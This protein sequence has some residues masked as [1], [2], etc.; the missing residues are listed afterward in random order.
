MPLTTTEIEALENALSLTKSGGVY[1]EGAR[2]QGGTANRWLLVGVGGVG[3]LTLLRVKHEIMSR[4]KLPT[5]GTGKPTGKPPEN[6][7]FLA[8]DTKDG[9][10]EKMSC[11]DT[12]FDGEEIVCTGA[13]KKSWATITKNMYAHKRQMPT[14]YAKFLPDTLPSPLPNT[15][16]AGAM[17][18]LGRIGL[19]YHQSEVIQKLT[20]AM[21]RVNAAAG[22]TQICLFAGLGGGTG[23]GSFIDIAFLLKQIFGAGGAAAPLSAYLFLPDTKDAASGGN[24]RLIN[25]VASLKELDQII[26]LGCEEHN[27]PYQ[28]GSGTQQITFTGNPFDY[29]YLINRTDANGIV[30]DSNSIV[31]DVAESIFELIADQTANDGDAH[32]GQSA[33]NDNANNWFGNASGQAPYP[34]VYRYMSTC[35]NIHRI[36]YLEI[37]TLVV[38]E[39][40]EKL[41]KEVFQNVVTR[42]KL[43]EDMEKLELTTPNADSNTDA[44]TNIEKAL[45]SKLGLN[46]PGQVGLYAKGIGRRDGYTKDDVW[47]V[48]D[49][50][51]IPYKDAYNATANYQSA[52]NANL[53]LLAGTNEAIGS[54]EKKLKELILEYI[55]RKDRGPIYLANVVGGVNESDN[56]I[57]LLTRVKSR[58]AGAAR[59]AAHQAALAEEDTENHTG[60]KEIW[61]YANGRRRP[62][63]RDL[64]DYL[65]YVD[66]WQQ[67][68]RLKMMYD[69]LVELCD[70]IIKVYQRYYDNILESLESTIL[71]VSTIFAGNKAEVV[72]KHTYYQKNPDEHILI[73]PLDF[74]KQYSTVFNGCVENAT[75]QFLK[76]IKDHLPEWIGVALN[77]DAQMP[78]TD[79]DFEKQDNAIRISSSLSDFIS[80]Y[81]NGL[82]GAVT[83]E[84]IYRQRFGANFDVAMQAEILRIYNSSYPFFA[85]NG[86][87]D[88]T[89]Q[90]YAI[91]YVPNSCAGIKAAAQTVQD[92]A[93][94]QLIDVIPSDDVSRISLIK[95]GEGYSLIMNKYLNDWEPV[96]DQAPSTANHL[97][98][99]WARSFPSPNV[100]TAWEITGYSANSSK[101]IADRNDKLR[102]IFRYCCQYGLIRLSQDPA[103]PLQAT[104]LVNADRILGKSAEEYLKTASLGGQTLQ[105]KATNLKTIFGNVWN[106]GTSET[107]IGMGTYKGGSDGSLED[108]MDNIMENTLRNSRLCEI[109]SEQYKL[110]KIYAALESSFKIPELYIK[111]LVCK[112]IKPMKSNFH[113]R[114][115]TDSTGATYQ[116]IV[117]DASA[118]TQKPDFHYRVY[119][120]FEPV[121]NTIATGH[122]TWHEQIEKNWDV[123]LKNEDREKINDYLQKK[124]Q[125]FTQSYTEFAAE[126]ERHLDDSL[127]EWNQKIADFY[128]M[129]TL[130]AKEL[131]IGLINDGDDDD[132]SEGT[133]DDDIYEDI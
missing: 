133:L 126:V 67:E 97:S 5:D 39:M 94:N 115:C 4:M 26:E 86:L 32:A 7:A 14:G 88:E 13:V 34:A 78:T 85:K 1:Y 100:Q 123:L 125:Q 35:S 72:A 53:G 114:L 122:S 18:I 40:F 44:V 99:K 45:M 129:C 37:N 73:Y 96:Y 62:T 46:T 108:R 92:G 111:A 17:R 90:S 6:I 60:F 74:K 65:Y 118:K 16:A 25:T 52:L 61:N 110:L 10:L 2:I 11:A 43:N 127:R 83:V 22:D 132:S 81:L 87:S 51:A 109:L 50:K 8:I 105:L 33:I 91:L 107:L 121:I 23:S 98:D 120:K 36:P 29:C 112:L 103:T 15:S 41:S 128:L 77:Q 63:S 84:T 69:Y 24:D 49:Y 76:H 19:F 79:Q 93:L 59:T 89:V 75:N 58:C 82:Y 102:N 12:K 130:Y 30:H 119:I 124:I 66:Q 116:E 54:L 38:S 113:V 48:S 47:G 131:S 104:L 31:E 71:A 27:S 57:A 101:K 55:T 20:T 28:F 70:S 106:A 95:V 80:Q 9:E 3:T 42:A 68:T 21:G 117:Q 56:L 64:D